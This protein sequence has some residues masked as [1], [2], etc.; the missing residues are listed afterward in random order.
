MTLPSTADITTLAA[1]IADYINRQGVRPEFSMETL[2]QDIWRILRERHN[3]HYFADIPYHHH[4]VRVAEDWSDYHETIWRDWL[5]FAFPYESWEDEVLYPLY[6]SHR[7]PWEEAVPGWRE[8]LHSFIWTWVRRSSAI[9]ADF[10]P[11]PELVEE[12]DEEAG[13]KERV[14]S[15]ILEHGSAKQKRTALK[16]I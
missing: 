8:G 16:G 5:D 12:S 6:G 3:G 1:L 2:C 15:Y 7:E 4:P 10:D 9:V 13:I 14:D 11:Q